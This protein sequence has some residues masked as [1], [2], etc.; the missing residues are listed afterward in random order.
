MPFLA[1][2]GRLNFGKL[3]FSASGGGAIF[4]GEKDELDY[5]VKYYTIDVK[6]AY[7]FY[8]TENWTYNVGIGFRKLFM[9]MRMEN[10]LGWAREEDH[11]SGPYFAIRAKFSSSEKWT[12][13]RRR[14]KKKAKEEAEE[15]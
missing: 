6:A 10:E 7:D 9:D 4:K 5:D 3:K 11:Y 2:A 15:E 12:Y 13:Q 1:A 8:T 14:D